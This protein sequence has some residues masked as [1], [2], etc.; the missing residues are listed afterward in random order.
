MADVTLEPIT[1]PSWPTCTNNLSWSEDH[2]AAAVGE[3]VHILTPRDHV[4]ST[5]STTSGW[6][7]ETIRINQ[8]SDAEWPRINLTPLRDFSIGEEQSHSTVCGLSWSPLGIGVHKRQ[9]L[10]VLTTNLLLSI[11]ESTGTPGS[12]RRT[13]VVN[14]YMIHDE[15]VN[16]RRSARIRAY[17]WL[18]PLSPAGQHRKST[19]YMVV[20]DD[21]GTVSVLRVQKSVSHRTGGWDISRLYGYQLLDKESDNDASYLQKALQTS[22][23]QSVKAG[24]WQ[25]LTDENA[26]LLRLNIDFTRGAAQKFSNRLALDCA[27]HNSGEFSF[28]ARESN[29]LDTNVAEEAH[30]Q[31]NLD[32]SLAKP[33]AEFSNTFNLQGRVRVRHWGLA[34][35]PD[36]SAIAACATFHPSDMVEHSTASRERCTV[37]FAKTQLTPGESEQAPCLDPR[38]EI[39]QWMRTHASVDNVK[40]DYDIKILS[41]AAGAVS[42]AFDD[43]PDLVAWTQEVTRLAD[44]FYNNAILDNDGDANMGATS[45]KKTTHEACEMCGTGL[46]F[47]QDLFLGQC[48]NG[49]MFVRCGISFLAIQQ[50]GISKYCSRCGKQFLDTAKLEPPAGPSLG[51]ALFEEFGVCPYCRGKFRG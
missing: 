46:D 3:G 6:H 34:E 24:R 5:L 50:P 15:G 23:V 45:A 27:I 26:S 16:Q 43:K 37:V 21:N 36:R 14:R 40:S 29:D 20:G 33:K 12:W 31:N 47:S 2:I 44:S 11:W 19:Q 10:A 22:P 32:A 48:S 8:F 17:S 49:H 1:L 51:V 7:V 25:N 4:K 38:L 41:V 28:Q 42:A 9:V 35:S 13:G 39:L 18:P 30:L